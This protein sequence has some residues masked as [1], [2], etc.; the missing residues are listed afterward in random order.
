MAN[1]VWH[2]LF[3]RGIVAS[4]DNFGARGTAPSHPLLLDYLAVRLVESQWSVKQLV[5][6]IVLSS[7]Y[8]M[9]CQADNSQA[10][11]KDPGNRLLWRHNRRR[12]PVESFRDAILAISDQLDESAG[13][14]SVASL[15]ESAISNTASQAGAAAY[16]GW[17]RRSV[18]MP[19]V[20]NNL[21][22]VFIAFDFSD[23]DVVTGARPVTT[24]PSQALWLLNSPF[25]SQAAEKIAKKL[26]SID[27]ERQRIDAMFKMILSRTA[28]G[29]EV[30][31]V[32]D[33]L[34]ESTVAE[35]QVDRLASKASRQIRTWSDICQ[36]VLASTH[37]LE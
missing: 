32:R 21:P 7:T 8:Q 3:G 13:G 26:M 12:L 17:I 20:R 6:E 9:S 11:E 2:H 30:R 27:D 22:H 16:Q 5:R 35:S 34:A 1:R 14:S 28:T 10:A 24:V 37:F 4:V 15:A 31:D 25:I 18:Y 19:I 33:Y 23:P 36:I 29:E